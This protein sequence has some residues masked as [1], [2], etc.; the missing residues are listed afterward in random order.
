MVRVAGHLQAFLPVGLRGLEIACQQRLARRRSRCKHAQQPGVPKR[1]PITMRSPPSLRVNPDLARRVNVIRRLG[2][3]H[4]AHKVSDYLPASWNA[5]GRGN[6]RTEK[7]RID[8]RAG[9]DASR[10]RHHRVQRR[11]WRRYQGHVCSRTFAYAWSS[12]SS[13]FSMSY[14]PFCC[15]WKP[16]DLGTIGRNL[17][18]KNSP[19]RPST[20]RSTA[21]SNWSLAFVFNK[22]STPGWDPAEGT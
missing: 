3:C 4:L 12:I 1:L 9:V 14:V 20:A 8:T 11:P 5:G 2:S 19:K 15:D 6:T 7:Q 21:R 16:S 22:T 18:A 10:Q 13:V 17:R